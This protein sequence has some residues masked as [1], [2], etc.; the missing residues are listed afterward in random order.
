[1]CYVALV[2]FVATEGEDNES[3]HWRGTLTLSL[4]HKKNDV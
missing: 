3:G 4:V 1:M 2:A